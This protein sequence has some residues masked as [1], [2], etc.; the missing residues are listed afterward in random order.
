MKPLNVGL[1]VEI[2]IGGRRGSGVGAWESR[3][4]GLADLAKTGPQLAIAT[5]SGK[6]TP[7]L[8]HLDANIMSFPALLKPLGLT[9]WTHL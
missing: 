7:N 5:G 1:L 9:Q 6:K 4:S 3:G 2:R 8:V